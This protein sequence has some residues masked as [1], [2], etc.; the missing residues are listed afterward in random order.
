MEYQKITNLLDKMP[1]QPIKF[2][3]KNW[4][5]VND[6]ARETHNTNSQIKYKSSMLTSCLRDKSDA[7][8]PVSGT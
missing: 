2:I 3:T 1:N 4:F 6:D 5:E 8:M 7:Y